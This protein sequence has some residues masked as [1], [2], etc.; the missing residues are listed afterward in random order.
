MIVVA[1][2]TPLRYLVIIGRQHLLPA[3]YGSVLIPPAVADELVHENTPAVVRSWLAAWPS[4]IEI[5]QPTRTLE[6]EDL[7]QGELQAIA[8]AE[9]A[10]ADIL[11]VDERD[12]RR[13]AER[14][15]LHVVGTLRVLADGASRGMTD[16][17]E[18]FKLLQDTNFRVS[19]ELLEALLEDFRRGR[20]K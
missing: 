4:W 6:I 19:S 8:L 3:L 11:L 18:A 5:R 12:A 14:R 9:E 20:R 2:T 13:E 16:L 15:H 17:E 10:G 7:D 1:D